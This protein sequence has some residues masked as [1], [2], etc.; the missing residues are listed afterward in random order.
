MKI[1]Q[2]TGQT[3]NQF[4]IYSNF[5]ADAIER[6]QKFAI[7]VPERGF[8]NFAN[9]L[10]SKYII[11]PLFSNRLVKLTGFSIYVDILTYIFNNKFSLIVFNYLIN[12][13]TNHSFELVG[14]QNKFSHFRHTHLNM[15]LETFRPS[16][17]ICYF[18]NEFMN[19]I[20]K[21]NDIIIGIHLRRGDYSAYANGRYLYSDFQYVTIMESVSKMFKKKNIAFLII[22]NQEIDQS[23]FSKFNCY[24]SNS[25]L[26]A[27]DLYLLG[28]TDYIAGP[29]STFSAWASIYESIP[30]YFIENLEFDFT[31]NDFIDIKNLWF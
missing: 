2:A 5:L 6:D 17:S 11:Y 22:S 23:S 29:P 13:F 7:W 19:K 15:I 14:I 20:K 30:L 25:K 27:E 3:C 9:L 31:L 18:V 16:K 28:K 26:M 8:E 24:F 4:W 12:S 1:V 10:K 21:K